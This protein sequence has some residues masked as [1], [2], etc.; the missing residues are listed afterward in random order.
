[1]CPEACTC[2]GVERVELPIGAAKD[3]GRSVGGEGGGGEDGL[4]RWCGKAPRR[5][6]REARAAR[7]RVPALDGAA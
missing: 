3:D 2:I 6:K 1:M 4:R 5:L 7:L